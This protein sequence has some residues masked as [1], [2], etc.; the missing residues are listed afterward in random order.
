MNSLVKF[1][2][3]PQQY[4]LITA[5]YIKN[6]SRFRAL[7]FLFVL[8]GNF[9][10]CAGNSLFEFGRVGNSDRAAVA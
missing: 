5:F 9:F 1:L 2:K 7:V 4:A 10:G 3:L 6:E 8:C